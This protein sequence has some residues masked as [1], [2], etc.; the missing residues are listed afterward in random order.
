MKIIR[1]VEKIQIYSPFPFNPFDFLG[2]GWC[3][4]V[5]FSFACD[6]KLL[7]GLEMVVLFCLTELSVDSPCFSIL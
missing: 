4:F 7:M 2:R 5:G 3:L 6:N 1:T